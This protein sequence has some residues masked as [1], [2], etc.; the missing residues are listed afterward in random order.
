[1]DEKFEFNDSMT[2]LRDDHLPEKACP[3]FDTMI[4]SINLDITQAYAEIFEILLFD[5]EIDA[6]LPRRVCNELVE[7]ILNCAAGTT[8]QSNI[9]SFVHRLRYYWQEFAD[10]I[11]KTVTAP[12]LPSSAVCTLLSHCVDTVSSIK[13]T[14]IVP[15]L[16]IT[17]P[18][19]YNPPK[20]GRAYYFNEHGCQVRQM[21]KF[22]VDKGK[23]PN[24]TFD[25]APA[26]ICNKLFPRVS[27]QGMPYIFLWFCPK[28][29]HCY[30]FH[31]IPE[32]EGR[33]NTHASLYTHLEKPPRELF[34]DFAWGL[35]EY[36]HIRESGYFSNTRFFHDVFH[37]FSHTVILR[38][39]PRAVYF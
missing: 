4:S 19:T 5:S 11:E 16:P 24:S 30:G 15:D 25:E 21:R 9:N 37:G 8:T 35:S 38:L 14:D 34:Y 12:V 20:Y 2:D 23:H 28:H 39:N 10:L 33:K 18:S 22:S 36:C 1:M 26:V 17:I 32:S 29:G 6:V 13:E 31:T 27:K 3:A 7:F